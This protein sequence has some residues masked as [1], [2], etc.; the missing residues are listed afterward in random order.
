MIY[1]N[2]LKWYLALTKRY[3]MHAPA[4]VGM[5]AASFLERRDWDHN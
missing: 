5:Y 4:P 3:S 1:R 2:I